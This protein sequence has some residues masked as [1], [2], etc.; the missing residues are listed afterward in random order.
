MIEI[1]VGDCQRLGRGAISGVGTARGLSKGDR[2]RFETTGEAKERHC[3]KERFEHE[4]SW[5]LG[6]FHP[7][8]FTWA[9]GGDCDIGQCDFCQKGTSDQC[10]W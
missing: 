10:G 1:E 8:L 9:A 2:L 5:D 4:F 3:S 7:T 6:Q